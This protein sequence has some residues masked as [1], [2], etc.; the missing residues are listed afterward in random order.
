MFLPVSMFQSLAVLSMDPWYKKDLW[1]GSDPGDQT[2][3]TRF[4]KRAR[5]KFLATCR[6]SHPISLICSYFGCLVETSRGNL[7]AIG[8]V[9]GQA[10]NHV[11]VAFQGELLLARQSVPHFAASVVTPRDESFNKAYLSPF[12][13]N[14]QFV[15]GNT[16]VFKVLKSSNC[17]FFLLYIFSISFRINAFNW[18]VCFSV[19]MGSDVFISSTKA[20]TSVLD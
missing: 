4:Q 14:A 19:I 11:F 13:L 17:W 12:L 3:C 6:H 9:E 20:S 18:G 15:R 5:T 1:R 7:V 8:I 10:V 2:E 16:C